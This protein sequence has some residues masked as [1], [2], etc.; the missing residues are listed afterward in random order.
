MISGALSNTK[1]SE[2]VYKCRSCET[3]HKLNNASQVC[4]VFQKLLKMT[5]QNQLKLVIVYLITTTLSQ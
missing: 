2:T 1:S 4:S 5:E 3:I